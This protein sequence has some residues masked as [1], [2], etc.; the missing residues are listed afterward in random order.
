F[1]NRTSPLGAR[2]RI[3]VA[4]FPSPICQMMFLGAPA[5]AV[6]VVAGFASGAVAIIGFE[7][8]APFSGAS[9][10]APAIAFVCPCAWAEAAGL[11]TIA[12]GGA[13]L[14][15]SIANPNNVSA[16]KIVDASAP[17]LVLRFQNSAAI[18][19]GAIAAKPE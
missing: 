11:A 8:S 14:P 15:C 3:T 9:G 17:H 18:I 2:E 13:G 19:T 16:T 10:L 1:K 12:G 5:G 4:S 6:G 7:P